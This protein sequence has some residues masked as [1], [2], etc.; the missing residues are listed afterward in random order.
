MEQFTSCT[1]TGHV[2]VCISYTAENIFDDISYNA[3]DSRHGTF[4][5]FF[6]FAL[7]KWH[8][9]I[10]SF[11]FAHDMM[12]AEDETGDK[13]VSVQLDDEESWLNF[14]DVPGSEVCVQTSPKN[15]T[16]VLV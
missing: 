7:Y 6:E 2:I 16:P 9:F 14:I 10:H 4:A 13:L 1:S 12:C 3:C 11:V 5:A 15:G 8:L